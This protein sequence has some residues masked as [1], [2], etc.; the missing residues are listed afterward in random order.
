[1]ATSQLH[2][3]FSREEHVQAGSDRG[4]G[5]VFAGFFALVSVLSW[6]RGHTGWHWMQER[7]DKLSQFPFQ[8]PVITTALLANALRRCHAT[9]LY[10][11]AMR[12]L[13][14]LRACQ[15]VPRSRLVPAN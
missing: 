8:W 5:F 2:E 3:D 15:V 9:D 1:M 10:G 12:H 13:S 7:A 6:W 14:E 11:E 4:F